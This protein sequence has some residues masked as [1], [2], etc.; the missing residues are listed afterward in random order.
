MHHAA[1]RRAGGADAGQHRAPAPRRRWRRRHRP[2]PRSP[3]PR[4]CAVASAIPGAAAP[5]RE[6][7]ARCRTPLPRQPARAFQAEALHAADHDDR[8]A[9]RP[10][11]GS[12]SGRGGRPRPAA[13]A[14]PACRY[15]PAALQRAEGGLGLLGREDR[16]RQRPQR[17]LGQPRA[18]CRPAAP[19]RASGRARGISSASTANQVTLRRNGRSAHAA[20]L[21]EVALAEFDEAPEG[22]QQAEGALHRLAAQRVQHHVD[23]P[24]SAPGARAARRRSPGRGCRAPAPAPACRRKARFAPACRR[25]RRPC[26][27]RARATCSAASPTA[28]GAAM[29]QHALPGLDPRQLLERKDGGEEGDR[30]GRRGDGIEAGRQ[31][32]Q[33]LGAGQRMGAPAPPGAMPKTASPGLEARHA[34]PDRRDHAGAFHAERRAPVKPA[35]RISSGSSPCA[36]IR[37][38]KFRPAGRRRDSATSPGPGRGPAA[39]RPGQRA[40]LARLADHQPRRAAGR[41]R[42]RQSRAQQR[43]QAARPRSASPPARPPPHR[44]AFL[45]QPPRRD[46]GR[47]AGRRASMRR[48]ARPGMLVRQHAAGGGQAAAAGLAAMPPAATRQ[49]A[50]GTALRRRGEPPQRV[51]RAA[52]APR[53]APSGPGQRDHQ[54]CRAAPRG[55]GAPAWS[56]S[57]RRDPRPPRRR[58]RGG[59]ARAAPCADASSGHAPQ[60]RRG[61]ARSRP[62]ARG[63][64]PAAP[65]RARRPARTARASRRQPR[66]R[67]REPVAGTG[68]RALAAIPPGGILAAGEIPEQAGQRFGQQQQSPPARRRGAARP[69]APAPACRPQPRRG[70]QADDQVGG[71]RRASPAADPR[72][73]AEVRMPSASGGA[74]AA[75]PGSAGGAVDDAPA[76]GRQRGDGAPGRAQRRRHRP[77]ARAAAVAPARR[78]AK[79][80]SAAASTAAERVEARP[81]PAAAAQRRGGAGQRG[82]QRSAARGGPGQVERQARRSSQHRAPDLLRPAAGLV[83]RRGA[84]PAAVRHRAGRFGLQLQ[85]QRRAIGPVAPAG[86]RTARRCA[87][88]AQK[89][90]S[91]SAASLMSAARIGGA[92]GV[93]RRLGVDRRA[94]AP[95]SGVGRHRRRAGRQPAA[96]SSQP[97]SRIRCSQTSWQVATTAPAA[98]RSTRSAASAAVP[99]RGQR[100]RRRLRP[101][102][103]RDARPGGRC[104]PA[105]ATA[106]SGRHRVRQQRDQPLQRAIQQHRVQQEAAASAAPPPAAA[107]APRPRPAASSAS[108]RSTGLEG[109]AVVEPAARRPGAHHLGP[110]GRGCRGGGGSA[111]GVGQARQGGDAARARAGVQGPPP[112][113]GGFPA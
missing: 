45:R 59:E 72:T 14:S 33:R 64:R 32:R 73:T 85:Q 88:A 30:H 96:G 105:P 112:G 40:E 49:S 58:Q 6:T 83:A 103:P 61:R 20:V 69:P 46:L 92:R 74:S 8:A 84:Q 93:Q 50:G 34:R 80:A 109:R 29:D 39:R 53:Q 19:A 57:S 101:A 63:R 102:R 87:A 67:A 2:S 13:G 113:G 98:S 41:R 31:R 38:R 70:A 68:Q 62:R 3:A 60:H 75:R 47:Q 77:P 104:A 66:P 21:D 97:G 76:A 55:G 79:A 12:G 108:T 23:A 28:A 9:R 17:A 94:A 86:A 5:R 48:S 99:R 100:E 81:A 26:A 44:P 111:G 4:A 78:A 106:G 24:S 65:A 16:A 42:R 25:W 11:I 7:S 37:S 52:S 90:S 1:D 91:S 71:E 82:G 89:P 43:H 51:S 54:R 95:G 56:R 18:R 36:H 35:S 110:R 107:A 15:A 22:P 10:G 27:P